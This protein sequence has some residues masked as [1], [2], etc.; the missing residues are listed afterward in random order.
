M[1]PLRVLAASSK[2]GLLTLLGNCLVRECEAANPK[3]L[4]SVAQ[5]W[6]ADRDGWN[7]FED[8]ADYSTVGEY[9]FSCM[10]DFN[11]NS[12]LKKN[13]CIGSLV[14]FAHGSCSGAGRSA[15]V[16]LYSRK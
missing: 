7:A 9:N 6:I 16:L 10:K 14:I 5:N 8:F 12:K 2:H 4:I 13:Q 15:R 1:M 3:P 11:P